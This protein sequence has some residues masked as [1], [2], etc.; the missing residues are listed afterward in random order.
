MDRR[1]VDDVEAE[2]RELR[3]H[4]GDAAEAAER[5]REQLVPRPEARQLAVDVDVEQR[6][7]DLAVA[8]ARLGGEP[9]FDRRDRPA[10]Q[11]RP[12]RELTG[13]VLL[14]C[15]R[16]AP[17]L[18]LPGRDPVGPGGDSELPAPWPVDGE[19]AAE[20]VVAEVR[21]RHLAQRAS[22]RRAARASRAERVV[23]VLEDGRVDVDPIPDR[24][25]DRG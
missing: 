22:P 17:Q 16:L 25:L 23:A 6:R 18:V 8:V 2:L 1:E 21:E 14:P 7:H 12:F 11:H 13:E 9:L 20:A 3:Q 19:R 24:A 10:E 5:A 4:L 15:R